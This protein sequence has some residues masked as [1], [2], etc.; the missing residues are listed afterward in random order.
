MNTSSSADL[1]VAAETFF[2]FA[3]ATIL[4]LYIKYEKFR[5]F[6]FIPLSF[7]INIAM[8]RICNATGEQMMFRKFK[9]EFLNAL[10]CEPSLLMLSSL[11]IHRSEYA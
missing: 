2:F 5:S 6:F 11:T 8:V 7:E 9:L 3:K 4:F 1:C 10:C